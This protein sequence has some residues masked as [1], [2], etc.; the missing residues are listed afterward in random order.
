MAQIVRIRY[1]QSNSWDTIIYPE[2]TL[3]QIKDMSD[4]S[5]TVLA[6]L[7]APSSSGDFYLKISS[8]GMPSLTSKDVLRNDIGAAPK[9]HNHTMSQITG[10]TGPSGAM[11]SKASLDSATNKI[12]TEHIPDWL[13]GGLKFKSVISGSTLNLSTEYNQTLGLTDD[14]TG[15]GTYY[16]VTSNSLA[17]STGEIAE[18]KTTDEHEASGTSS[19]TVTLEKGDWLIY[20]GKNNND[21]AAS[22]SNKLQFDVINNVYE[23]AKTT[24]AGVVKLTNPENITNRE[25]LNFNSPAPGESVVTEKLLKKLLKEI[26]YKSTAPASSNEGDL[27]FEIITQGA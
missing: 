23:I 6:N 12:N 4:V 26:H 21:A 13:F 8:T 16:I 18:F 10:L 14:K 27:W 19:G 24:Y 22:T 3:D 2:T 9:N 25:A 7:Q 1:R 5:K 17:I 11:A 15:I 20:R